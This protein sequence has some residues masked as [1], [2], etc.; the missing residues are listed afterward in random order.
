M[1][2]RCVVDAGEAG[3][4]EALVVEFPELV[5]VGA[6]PLP[7]FVVPFVFEA[8]GNAVFAEAP[9]GFLEAVVELALPLALEDALFSSRPLRK[10]V[11]LRHCESGE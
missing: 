5:A 3:L 6:E 11:R 4:H 7:F 9:E 2:D 10:V 1:V 8:D